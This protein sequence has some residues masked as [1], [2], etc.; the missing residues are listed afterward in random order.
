MPMERR[1][2]ETPGTDRALSASNDGPRFP[3]IGP[4]VLGIPL[5]RPHGHQPLHPE[6]PERGELADQAFDPLGEDP[7]LLGFAPAVDLDEHGQDL[8]ERGAPLVELGAELRGIHGLDHVEDLDGPL[9]LVL[10]EVADEVPADPAADRR[11]VG[12]GVLDIVL[13]DDSDAGGDGF[14]D[15]VGGLA[16]GR[17]DE[18]DAGGSSSRMRWTLSAIMAG[19]LYRISVL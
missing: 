8:A 2:I 7:R 15:P 11:E 13:A 12:D 16:L 9:G 3:E 6:V 10:L 1:D 19:I 17:R 14:E 4:G 5:E 18:L